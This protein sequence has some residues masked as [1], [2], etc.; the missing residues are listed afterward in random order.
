[1]KVVGECVKQ[2]GTAGLFAKVTVEL[3]GHKGDPSVVVRSQ[4]PP[5]KLA[6]ALAAAAEQGI[7]SALQSGE[8]G[9]P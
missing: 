2:A 8:L 1:V 4:V 7:L 5:D 9:Y 6:P 3:E